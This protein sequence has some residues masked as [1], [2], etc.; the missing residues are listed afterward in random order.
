LL[1]RPNFSKLLCDAKVICRIALP[2][3]LQLYPSWLWIGDLC[4]GSLRLPYER[5]VRQRELKSA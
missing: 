4:R 2:F 1:F 3:H 5:A